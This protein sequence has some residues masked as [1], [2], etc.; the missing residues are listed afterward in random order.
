MKS[1]HAKS[2]YNIAIDF[3]S[4]M[5]KWVIHTYRDSEYFIPEQVHFYSTV[6]N[7]FTMEA[8]E[9]RYASLCPNFPLYH[10]QR[11][12]ITGIGGEFVTCKFDYLNEI[13]SFTAGVLNVVPNTNTII[14]VGAEEAWVG[15]VNTEGTCDQLVMNEKCA[16]GSGFFLETMNHLFDCTFD[17]LNQWG[18]Q[19]SES[20]PLNTHCPVFAESEVIS[21]IHEQANPHA[22]IRGVFEALVGKIYSLT[23]RIPCMPPLVV[24]G[25]VASSPLFQTLLAERLGFS[26]LFMERPQFVECEGILHLLQ[27]SHLRRRLRV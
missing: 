24:G 2:S 7:F 1:D 6:S 18:L 20:I 10:A 12:G 3:G 19:A 25:G 14:K 22:I 11:I 5:T 4:R 26:P 15:I 27:S 21:R 16:A 8:F 23:L 17:Q 13:R 9:A